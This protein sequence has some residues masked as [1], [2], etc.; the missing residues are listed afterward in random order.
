MTKPFKNELDTISFGIPLDEC[1]ITADI[2]SYGRIT[3]AEYNISNDKI[4]FTLSSKLFATSKNIGAIT[5][6][7]FSEIMPIIREAFSIAI[8]PDFLYKKALLYRVDVKKD[9]V[10]KENPEFYISDKRR[11]FKRNTAKY[12]IHNYQ[13]T[14][15]THGLA[16]VP[17][18]KANYRFS[19]YN[20]GR[21]MSLKRNKGIR[22]K[23]SYEY[24]NKVNHMIRCELQLRKFAD[25]KKVFHIPHGKDQTFETIFACPHDVVYEQFIKL[26]KG[27]NNEC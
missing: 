20:K 26:M 23:F 15:Y 19:I 25:I 17:K 22:E 3:G 21:E 1:E 14:T 18:S 9:I 5:L 6:N 24:L 11:F 4:Y 13:N 2:T 10:T 27:V 16:I 12:E 7:N 8:D